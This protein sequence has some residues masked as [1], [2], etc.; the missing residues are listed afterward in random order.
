[1]GS[2]QKKNLAAARSNRG[3]R[4]GKWH[5]RVFFLAASI[6]GIMGWVRTL[7]ITIST[8]RLISRRRHGLVLADDDEP[9]L[10]LIHSS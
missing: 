6:L 9:F 10:S 2:N 5:R 1:M 4:G 8:L 3:K 7:P